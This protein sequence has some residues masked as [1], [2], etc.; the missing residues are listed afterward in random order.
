MNLTDLITIFKDYDLND[1]ISVD[2][3]VTI[4]ETRTIRSYRRAE[5]PFQ[6]FAQY[7]QTTITDD[8]DKQL[9]LDLASTWQYH[10]YQHDYNADDYLECDCDSDDTEITADEATDIFLEAIANAQDM[11]HE[12]PQVVHLLDTLYQQHQMIQ[13]LKK[14]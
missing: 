10:E 14:A 8:T 9:F 1:T 13:L 12:N 4:T 11:P 5:L 6:V 2:I 7:L 3:P